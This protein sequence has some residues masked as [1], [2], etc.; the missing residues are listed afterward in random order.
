MLT[1]V[2]LVHLSGPSTLTRNL[3]Y[4]YARKQIRQGGDS[5]STVYF[6]RKAST[7]GKPFRM[8]DATLHLRRRR[9]SKSAWRPRLV[10]EWMLKHKPKASP[11]YIKSLVLLCYKNGVPQ[12]GQP[13][14]AD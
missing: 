4:R 14:S 3:L 12:K 10:G 9:E 11:I 8:D 6:W 7:N 1:L 13:E 5:G 2:Q